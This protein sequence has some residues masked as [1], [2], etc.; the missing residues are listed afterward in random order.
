VCK[1]QAGKPVLRDHLSCRGNTGFGVARALP[2]REH[3]LPAEFL[4]PPRKLFRQSE[5]QRRVGLSRC[6]ILLVPL[7]PLGQL[8]FQVRLQGP[9]QHDH[10]V[11]AAFAVADGE[12]V[13]HQVEVMDA[14]LTTL[15]PPQSCPV[16]QPGHEPKQ[17]VASLDSVQ[18]AAHFF[19]RQHCWQPFGPPRPQGRER[20]DRGS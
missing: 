6:Q 11:L 9:G 12:L 7:P 8:V 2:D 16:E 14:D 13:P 20:R 3:I 17:P 19:G 10:P 15:L 4:R 18:E 1:G 5:R